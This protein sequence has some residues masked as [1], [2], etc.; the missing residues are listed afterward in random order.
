MVT[1]GF[2]DGIRFA[3]GIAD[4]TA[5][6]A[7]T[8]DKGEISFRQR[9]AGAALLRGLALALREAAD[10]LAAVQARA[11]ARTEASAP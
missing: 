1:L 6:A 5:V 2:L 11:E 8:S 4:K 10:E 3:A 7:A 9:E